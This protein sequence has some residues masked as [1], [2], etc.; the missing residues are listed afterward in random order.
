MSFPA[1]PFCVSTHRPVSLLHLSRL[2]VR[3]HVYLRMCVCVCVCLCMW[4]SERWKVKGESPEEAEQMS[5]GSVQVYDLKPVQKQ[6][7]ELFVP[8][9]S[10]ACM[11]LCLTDEVIDEPNSLF[12]AAAGT[13]ICLFQE[14][15]LNNRKDQ[16]KTQTKSLV[17]A[18]QYL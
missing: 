16:N 11:K 2:S 5:G 14:T 4:I 6:W 10:L 18:T 13:W 17:Q 7:G 15:C 3:A 8:S 12:K 1:W 9:S